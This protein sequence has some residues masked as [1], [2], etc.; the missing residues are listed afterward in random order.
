M[1]KAIVNTHGHIDHVLGCLYLKEK[2]KLPF[3]IHEMELP[4][5]ENAV[6]FGDFFG[7]D[8]EPP[9][10][11]DHYLIEGHDFKFGISSL[12]IYHVPGHSEGSIALYSEPDK[13]IITGDVLFYGSI[14]RTDLPGGNYNTLVKQ[15]RE[16]WDFSQRSS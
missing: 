6:Q 9:P 10:A 7:I 5:L 1:I 13:I 8:A 15:I 16:R 4:L 2:Y 3:Y 12:Q 14:G 11:P